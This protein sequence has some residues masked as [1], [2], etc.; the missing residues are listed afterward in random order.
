MG[1]SQVRCRRVTPTHVLFKLTA[2][3]MNIIS[4]YIKLLLVAIM[5]KDPIRLAEL[6]RALSP[7]SFR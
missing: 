5:S 2:S 4:V 1:V 3:G 6:R 7:S